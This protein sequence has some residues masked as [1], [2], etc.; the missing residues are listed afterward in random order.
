MR[1][2]IG[3]FIYWYLLANFMLIEAL[4][5][6]AGV[7]VILILA[8]I[9]IKHSI[10]LAGHF[11]LSG[12]FIGLTILSIGTSIPEIITH[13]IGSVNIVKDP[14]TMDTLSGLLIGTNIGSD[15][16]QQ[17]FVLAI[18]GLLG[19]VVVYKRNLNM[20]VG[21]LIGAAALVWLF[22]LGGKINRIEGLLLVVAYVAYLIYLKIRNVKEK[23]INLNHLPKKNIVWAFFLI[24]IGFIIMGFATDEVL[25]ASTILVKSLPISASFFGV[26]LLGIASAL[27]ELTTSLLAVLRK[28]KDISVGILIGSNI[29][30]PLFGIGIGALISSYT[31]P[32]VVVLYDLPVKIGTALLIY[33]FLF[34]HEK[35]NKLNSIVLIVLFIAYLIIRQVYFPVDF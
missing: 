14:S 33:Y 31:V 5:I 12:T 20:E 1:F 24:I 8:E 32:D 7:V 28:K 30:N 4:T 2:S 16:F 9:I 21:A 29:T 34:K 10:K 35:L 18:I 17:N 25:K 19:A 26:I 3:R 15:I 27:P 13:I 23:T 22:A 11:G 6:L